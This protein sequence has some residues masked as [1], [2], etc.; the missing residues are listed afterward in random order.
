MTT[1][2]A[3]ARRAPLSRERVLREA[4]RIADE[5]GIDSLTMRRLAQQL[6]V[7]AMSIY[8]HVRGKD[9]VLTGAIDLVFD[10]VTRRATA[11]VTPVPPSWR[12]HLRA[13]ILTAREVLLLHPWVPRALESSGTMTPAVAAWVDANIGVMRSGG[14]SWD[15]IHHSMHTLASRQFGF[16]QELIL[17]DP[18][19]SEGEI[20]PVQAA[21]LAQLMPN[22]Q[23]MLQDVV[24]DDDVGTLGWCD[25]RAE[26]EFALDILLEGIERRAAGEGGGIRRP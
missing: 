23:A 19:D 21:A 7:E 12:E 15:L 17:D 3:T 20:D 2:R 24:H 18:T 4:I 11:A 6:E 26:F 1:V 16:S 22:V 8:H 13:R 5:G 25:D 9:A 14:L 10:D